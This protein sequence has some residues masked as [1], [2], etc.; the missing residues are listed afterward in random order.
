M[1]R[2]VDHTRRREA[3]EPLEDEMKRWKLLVAAL[4]VAAFAVP[5]AALAMSPM[6]PQLSAKL[7]GSIEVPPGAMA[8]AH[9]I[10][11]L[12]LTAKTG[13]VC[14]TIDITGVAKP[15]AAHIHKAPAGKAGAV[16][17]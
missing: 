2:R 6:H 13:K 11:N 3:P 14:W 17:A 4:A 1:R 5:V 12:D 10:V 16:V 15:S 7:V 8:S 9:G